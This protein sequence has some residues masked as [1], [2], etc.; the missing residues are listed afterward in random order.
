MI[1]LMKVKNKQKTCHMAPHVAFL[2]RFR[3]WGRWVA[4]FGFVTGYKY[5]KLQI[6]SKRHGAA[7]DW[8]ERRICFLLD[9]FSGLNV[10]RIT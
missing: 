10:E 9:C 4:G 3:C 8:L 1:L 5:I 6:E 7:G 2:L